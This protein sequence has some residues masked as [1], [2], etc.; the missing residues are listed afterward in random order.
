MSDKLTNKKYREFC[1][2]YKE[3]IL[4]LLEKK[5][6]ISTSELTLQEQLRRLGRQRPAPKF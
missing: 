1:E 4:K 6:V 3:D 5:G 2:I